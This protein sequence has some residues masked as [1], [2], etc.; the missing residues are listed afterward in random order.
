MKL[1]VFMGSPRKGS[2]TDI[3]AD[4]VIEGAE[5]LTEINVEKIYLYDADIKYCTGCGVHTALQG[6][7]QCPLKD[8]MSAI[9]E[10]MQEADAFVFASPNHGRSVSAAMVNFIS[11]MMPLLKMYVQRDESGNIIHAESRPLIKGKKVVV[12]VSQGDSF[13]SSS[14]LPLMILDINARDFHLR[15]VGEVFSTGNLKRAQVREK[16]EDLNKAFAAGVRM[17][18]A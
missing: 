8:D 7:R 4:K 18:K 10:R 16:Q 14:A 2:N 1:M 6:S 9:L 3:L 15:K 11:R 5:S 13:P 12:V 17:V